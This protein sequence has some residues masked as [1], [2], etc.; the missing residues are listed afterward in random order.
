M[1]HMLTGRDHEYE[2]PFDFPPLRSLNPQ[3]TSTSEGREVSKS[4]VRDALP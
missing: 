2:T 3:L 4:Y 1:H